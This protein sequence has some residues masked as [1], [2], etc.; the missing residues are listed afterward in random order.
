[1]GGW[2]WTVRGA[3]RGVARTGGEGGG[4][5]GGGGEGGGDGGGDGGGGEGGGGDG[6]GEGGG[7]EGREHPRT[8]SAP[9]YS[10][11]CTIVSWI[12][13]LALPPEVSCPPKAS[14][15]WSAAA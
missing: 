6:G 14:S 9:L 4:G 12:I 5:E 10:T 13:E 3:G 11:P 1:M 15:L 2:Y 8:R 7:G